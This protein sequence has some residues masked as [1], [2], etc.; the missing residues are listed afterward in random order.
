MHSKILAL[1]A[2]ASGAVADFQVVCGIYANGFDGA[3]PGVA[4]LFYDDGSAPF[5][6]DDISSHVRHFSQTDVSGCG[7]LR[8]K[9]CD[10]DASPDEWN[11]EEIEMNDTQECTPSTQHWGGTESDAHFSETKLCPVV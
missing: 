3:G 2:L 5:S 8:C 6:C 10:L 1:I 11:I 9:G 4:C 7:G